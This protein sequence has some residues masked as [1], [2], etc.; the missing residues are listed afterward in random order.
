MYVRSY[1]SVFLPYISV[2][3]YVSRVCWRG[4]GVGLSESIKMLK[5][6][7]GVVVRFLVPKQKAQ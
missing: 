6:V 7:D 2:Q 3:A 4:G 5:N 1:K